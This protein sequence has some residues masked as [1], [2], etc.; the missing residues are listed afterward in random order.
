MDTI[1]GDILQI[2]GGLLL[3]FIAFKISGLLPPYKHDKVIQ[4][5]INLLMVNK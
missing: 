4:I 2:I 5:R 3:A 1:I